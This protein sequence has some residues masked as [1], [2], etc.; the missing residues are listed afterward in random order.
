MSK[1]SKERRAQSAERWELPE[2]SSPPERPR[3]VEETLDEPESNPQSAISNPK[4]ILV[5]H[6]PICLGSEI[7]YPGGEIGEDV[8]RQMPKFLKERFWQKGAEIPARAYAK[9][10]KHLQ[11]LFKEQK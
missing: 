9:L 10:A 4:Y 7:Y 3:F 8:Y 2:F 1:K 6:S 5:H 11:K